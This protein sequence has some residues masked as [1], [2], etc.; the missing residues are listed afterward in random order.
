MHNFSFDPRSAYTGRAPPKRGGGRGGGGVPFIPLSRVR[1]LLFFPSSLDAVS[2][3]RARR[4][5]I[6]PRKRTKG[7]D[8]GKR[9]PRDTRTMVAKQ[10][11]DAGNLTDDR[12]CPVPSFDYYFPVPPP[13]DDNNN[14]NNNNAFALFPP[15]LPFLLSP[16][17]LRMGIN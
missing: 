16:F 15:L 4:R 3:A 11:A 7:G 10:W 5:E 8:K 6:R 14:N 17:S 2:R 1:S 12:K 9:R 13:L